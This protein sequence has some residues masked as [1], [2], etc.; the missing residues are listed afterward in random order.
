MRVCVGYIPLEAY[1]LLVSHG[2]GNQEIK[3]LIEL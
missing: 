3:V 1:A 2:G